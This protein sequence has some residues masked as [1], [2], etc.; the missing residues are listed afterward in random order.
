[1]VFRLQHRF[2]QWTYK[3]MQRSLRSC[4]VFRLG[5]L[6]P[7]RVSTLSEKCNRLYV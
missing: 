1:M 7:E 6:S 2:K 5:P 4:T 3:R